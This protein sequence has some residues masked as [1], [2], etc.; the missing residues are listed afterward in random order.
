MHTVTRF[1]DWHRVSVETFERSAIVVNEGDGWTCS[2]RKRYKEM[3]RGGIGCKEV[4][5]EEVL[6][7]IKPGGKN[8]STRA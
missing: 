5:F 7:L 3:E 4:T 1:C 6:Q 2:L 8:Q